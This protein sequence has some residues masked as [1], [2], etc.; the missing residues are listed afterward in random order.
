MRRRPNEYVIFPFA[1]AAAGGA[2]G[3]TTALWTF[4]AIGVAAALPLLR[5][6]ARLGRDGH[7]APLR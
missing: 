3:W 4:A 5:L 7:L 6:R 1:F 2:L